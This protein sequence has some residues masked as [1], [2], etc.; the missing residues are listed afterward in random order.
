M[1]KITI[2]L[3]A[4]FA[5]FVGGATAQDF[6]DHK[7]VTLTSKAW[8]AY[9]K[10]KHDLAIT[11]AN[12]CIELY[13][14]EGKKM[15]KSLKDFAPEDKAST[16]WALNDVGTCLFIKGESLLKKGSSKE[17]MKVFK[18]LSDNLKFSQCWDAN[19]WFWKPAEAAKQKVVELSF[20]AE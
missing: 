18:E 13:M 16:F 10:G 6:G 3:F 8:E 2:T 1:K 12:K 20:D 5:L 17:A 7:S 15:Q 4:V 14:A 11:Y 19:G 9:G